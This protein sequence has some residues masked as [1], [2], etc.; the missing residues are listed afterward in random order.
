MSWNYSCPWCGAMLNPDK[1]IILTASRGEERVLIGFHPEP[2]NYELFLPPN[3]T[4]REGDHWDFFCPVC[5]ENL[6]TG[7]LE[8]LCELRVMRDNEEHQVFFSRIAG[9]RATLVVSKGPGKPRVKE[10]HG[11]HAERYSQLIMSVRY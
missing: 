10:E 11:D 1:T 2:G 7:E 5:R 8:G 6:L 4:I 9:E 3:V